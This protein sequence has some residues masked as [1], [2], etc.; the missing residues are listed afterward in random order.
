MSNLFKVT[1]PPTSSSYPINQQGHRH[2]DGSLPGHQAQPGAEGAVVGTGHREPPAGAAAA[3][4][5]ESAV[6]DSGEGSSTT[7]EQPKMT[8]VAGVLGAL[9]SHP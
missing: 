4:T 7:L 3:L 6:T 5:M 1:S 2:P 8:L 9:G